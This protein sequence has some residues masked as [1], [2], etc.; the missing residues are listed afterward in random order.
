MAEPSVIILIILTALSTVR[1]IF[2]AAKYIKKSSCT[3][4]KQG[5]NVELQGGNA[6]A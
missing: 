2:E 6:T 5:V 1:A 4:N 3:A